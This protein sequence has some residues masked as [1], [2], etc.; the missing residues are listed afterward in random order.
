MQP[1][2][3]EWLV[4]LKRAKVGNGRIFKSTRT[5]SLCTLENAGEDKL[6]GLLELRQKIMQKTRVLALIMMEK[7]LMCQMYAFVQKQSSA[8]L[9]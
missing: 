4:K 2:Q 8:V 7:F 3:L 5:D 1:P 6:D 9:F